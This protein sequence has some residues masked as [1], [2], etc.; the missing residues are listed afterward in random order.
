LSLIISTTKKQEIVKTIRACTES[1]AIFKADKLSF[2]N[3]SQ[4]QLFQN[5][6]FRKVPIII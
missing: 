6:Q 2:M 1:D 4:L 3:P 5:L